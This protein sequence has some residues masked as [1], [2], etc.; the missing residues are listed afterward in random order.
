MQINGPGCA[1]PHFQ[2]WNPQ[3]AAAPRLQHQHQPDSG[4]LAAIDY[5]HLG[6]R[7]PVQHYKIIFQQRQVGIEI[8]LGIVGL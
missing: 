3:V 4:G 1:S 2:R 5:G 8:L 6:F 7:P